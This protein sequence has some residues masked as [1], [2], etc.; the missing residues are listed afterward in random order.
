MNQVPYSYVRRVLVAL[1]LASIVLAA[2]LL[3]RNA[4]GV[5][6]LI[7]AGILFGIFLRTLSDAVGSVTRLRPR[8]SLTLTV[9]LVTAFLLVVGIFLVPRVADQTDQLTKG[10]PQTARQLEAWLSRYSWGERLLERSP[11]VGASE[12]PSLDM[13][14]RLTG[15]FSTLFSFL[16]N[17]VFILFIGLFTAANPASYRDGIVGLVPPQRRK[18]ARE[19]LSQVWRTLQDWLL[20]KLLAMLLVGLITGIGLM[21]LGTPF[22][23]TLALLAGFFE[24][25]PFVGPILAAIPA[26][27]VGLTESPWQALYVALLYLIIQQLEGNLITPL[28]YKHTVALPPVLTLAAVLI[29]GTLFGF[30]GLLV[31]TPLLAVVVVLVRTLYK[32]DVLGD[33]AGG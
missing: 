31:A 33:P 12:L 7:F 27:L 8:W 1:A 15:T 30:L 19:V 25:I 14:S 17:L 22:A 3:L 24:L 6:L 20:G 23:L 28:V 26:V 32:Q 5:L 18:R 2:G 4:A 21:V 16:T 11:L 29:M 9:V 13:L 10:L